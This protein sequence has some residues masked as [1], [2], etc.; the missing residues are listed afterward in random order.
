M[1]SYTDDFKRRAVSRYANGE[2]SG[3][4]CKDLKITH[5][6]LGKWRKKFP[7]GK[8]KSGG[9]KWRG[10]AVAQSSGNGSG[11]LAAITFLEQ[12]LDAMGNERSRQHAL[13]ELA[14]VTLK[15]T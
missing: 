9:F 15:G 3:V 5:A 2:K 8:V 14:L 11:S 6:M 4:I 13:V 12:A 1:K 7:V 10:K